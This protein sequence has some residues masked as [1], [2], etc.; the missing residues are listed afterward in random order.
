MFPTADTDNNFPKAKKLKKHES[1]TRTFLEEALGS[2]SMVPII[3][4]VP[5]EDV[6]KV[7]ESVQNNFKATL[8]DNFTEEPEPG[9]FAEVATQVQMP[10]NV[11][12]QDVPM[13]ATASTS[14]SF[15]AQYDEQEVT[16]CER[17]T[18]MTEEEPLRYFSPP[19]G[20][21]FGDLNPHESGPQQFDYSSQPSTSQPQTRNR[22]T[23]FEN[24]TTC[25]TGTSMMGEQFPDCT[26]HIYTQTP[27]YPM[28]SSDPSNWSWSNT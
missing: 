28:S 23:M 1:A 9:N 14:T 22:G 7:V 24:V 26:R 11:Q 4:L 6:Q 13:Y 15:A 19:Y 18:M 3:L 10:F 16:F 5:P 27:N 2:S 20:A 17:G 12:N 8:V 21:E 25:N